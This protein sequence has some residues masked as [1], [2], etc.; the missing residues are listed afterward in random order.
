MASSEISMAT[1]DR[2]TVSRTVLSSLEVHAP[3]VEQKLQELLF[4]EGPPKKLTIAGFLAALANTLG[5]SVNALSQADAAHSAELGDD[6]AARNE[7]DQSLASLRE[8]L[9]DGRATLQ[10]AYGEAALRPYGLDGETPTNPELL[11]Q[12]GH[13][14]STA[15]KTRPL[16]EKPKRASVKVDIKAMGEEI[17]AATQRFDAA[18]KAV[19]REE[20]EAQLTLQRRTETET[21]W[22]DRYQGVADTVTGLYEL[23]GRQDLADRVRPTSRRR[24]GLPEEGDTPGAT[25][26]TPG[27]GGGSAPTG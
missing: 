6:T 20:R 17:H 18:L 8:L 26:A 24:A 9:V 13:K 14:C 5:A 22:H 21:V 7:R 4:P 12:R 27:A 25:P 16:T 11:L 3:E 23:I 10:S 2:T 15:M 1:A 19:A